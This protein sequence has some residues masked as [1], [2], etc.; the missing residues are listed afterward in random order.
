MASPPFIVVAGLDPAIHAFIT[1][2]SARRA[3]P[4]MPGPSPGRTISNRLVYHGQPCR[5]EEG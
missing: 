4:W 3:V 5:A 1:R 2:R